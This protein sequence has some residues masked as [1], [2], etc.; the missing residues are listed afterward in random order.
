MIRQFAQVVMAAA[1]TA[2]TVEKDDAAAA[3]WND[4]C[5]HCIDEGYL[6]CS[7]DGITGTCYDASC[8]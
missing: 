5:Y 2:A 4:M 7:V 8:E 3:K 6:F 1:V